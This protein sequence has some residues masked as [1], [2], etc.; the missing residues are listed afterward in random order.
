M[1]RRAFLQTALGTALSGSLI[2]KSTQGT[3]GRGGFPLTPKVLTQNTSAS[4]QRPCFAPDGLTVLFMRAA[5]TGGNV[6][7]STDFYSTLIINKPGQERLFASAASLPANAGP[8]GLT[9]PD[10]SWTRAAY[11]IAF[12]TNTSVLLMDALTKKIQ[13][14][15]GLVGKPA[16]HRVFEYPSWYPDGL[17][18]AATNYFSFDQQIPP[19]ELQPYL[20]RY[21]LLTQ[22]VTQLTSGKYSAHAPIPNNIWP[23]MCSVSHIPSLQYGLKP[24]VAFAGQLPVSTG[25]NQDDNQVWILEPAQQANTLGTVRLINPGMPAAQQQARAPWWSPNGKYVAFE[26]NR[27]TGSNYQILVQA[28]KPP[29][30]VTQLTPADWTVQHAKW[31]PLGNRV[32][33]GYAIKG[34]QNAQ[35]IAYVDI[36][37]LCFL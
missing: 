34:A 20:L 10:W 25:Y 17:S 21:D 1:R 6:S 16:E 27:Y 18:L 9:R 19:A 7:D 30:Q 5:V 32:V 36:P 23:G 8:G 24:L 4:D 22:K 12:S 26:S 33:F 3:A 2:Q 11:Q 31:S 29:Y 13:T 28:L 35:G 37:P 15:P 14:I